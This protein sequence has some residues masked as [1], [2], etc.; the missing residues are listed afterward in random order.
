MEN[1]RVFGKSKKGEAHHK[2]LNQDAIYFNQKDD[3]I[4]AVICDGVS[5]CSNSNIG[6][7]LACEILREYLIHNFDNIIQNR[8]YFKKEILSII[9]NEFQ[10]EA[11]KKNID[12]FSLGTTL[13]FVV[14]KNNIFVCGQIGD[15]MIGCFC[16]D[17]YGIK[18]LPSRNSELLNS[19]TYTVFDDEKYFEIMQGSFKDIDAFLLATDGLNN[20]IYKENSNYLT[21]ESLCLLE[22]KKFKIIRNIY[23]FSRKSDDDIS[24]ISIV[25]QN[26]KF[27]TI[28]MSDKWICQCKNAYPFG[29]S[30][31]PRCKKRCE[32]LY[33]NKS[34]FEIKD[35]YVFFGYLQK[36][37]NGNSKK[38]YGVKI[39]NNMLFYNYINWLFRLD[40]K[41]LSNLNKKEFVIKGYISHYIMKFKKKKFSAK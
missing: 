37:I 3:Y 19:T 38:I 16:K 18:L 22:D 9:Q 20:I 24:F 12:V 32:D 39:K 27:H 2:K 5:K 7:N 35:K 10:K 23:R 26:A 11:E 14:I 28:T 21:K 33:Y 25:K 41:Y 17:K 4:I 8:D 40:K 29:Q 1:I 13:G 34:F 6:S 36:Y 15:G 31:C 30:Y